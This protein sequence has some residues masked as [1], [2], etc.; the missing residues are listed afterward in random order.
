MDAETV[1][2][3]SINL[4]GKGELDEWRPQNLRLGANLYL[5]LYTL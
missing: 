5:M 1:H 3:D 2:E 4:G